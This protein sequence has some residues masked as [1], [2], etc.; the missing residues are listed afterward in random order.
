MFKIY[1]NY[2][3]GKRNKGVDK[4]LFVLV[5]MDA[6]I[7]YEKNFSLSGTNP[8]K[9]LPQGKIYYQENSQRIFVRKFAIGQTGSVDRKTRQCRE[10][11]QAEYQYQTS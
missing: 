9:N 7:Q 4:L 1:L 10:S 11:N 6:H 3:E 2:L 8:E 5:Q